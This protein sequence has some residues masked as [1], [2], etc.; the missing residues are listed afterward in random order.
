MNGV[1][2]NTARTPQEYRA[3]L[4]DGFGKSRQEHIPRLAW[5]VHKKRSQDHGREGF[6]ISLQQHF[7]DVL[8]REVEADRVNGR[9]LVDWISRVPMD[10]SR[11]RVDE[12]AGASLSRVLEKPVCAPDVDIEQVSRRFRKVSMVTRLSEVDYNINLRRQSVDLLKRPCQVADHGLYA[13]GE[14]RID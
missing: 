4:D 11:R 10:S 13:L 9:L 8:G 2:S 5:T 6:A 14:A 7:T 12:S 3:P 1:Q